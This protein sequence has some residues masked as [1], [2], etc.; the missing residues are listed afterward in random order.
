MKNYI[1]SKYFQ[2]NMIINDINLNVIT[3]NLRK[4]YI[5]IFA[6]LNLINLKIDTETIIKT[7]HLQ[8][9]IECI[10]NQK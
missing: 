8:F 7:L 3:I 6:L 10:S 1:I 2:K 9:S 5:Q 4:Q